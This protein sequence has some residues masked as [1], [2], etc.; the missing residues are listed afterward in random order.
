MNSIK[1]A[2]LKDI[3][4][5][6]HDTAPIFF[7][8]ET[9]P[10]E[11]TVMAQHLVPKYKAPANYN[12]PE[13]IEA[14]I[15]KK[16]QE[17]WDK[18]ALDPVSGEV[19]SFG[20]RYKGVNYIMDEF[21][22]LPEIEVA[23]LTGVERLAQVSNHRQ[24]IGHNIH[25]FDLPFLV[26]RFWANGMTMPLGWRSGNYWNSWFVDTMK[27]FGLGKWKDTI[28]LDRLARFLGHTTGKEG[29][30]GEK[31][32]ELLLADREAALKYLGKDL[33]LTQFVYE[34]MS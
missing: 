4:F 14:Y 22:D 3:G 16:E 26:R 24:W 34:K 11:K 2:E 23:I 19:V 29:Q 12:D 18:A 33:E 21:E 32:H 13:K 31:F 10:S 8:I 1:I 27:M 15:L 28:S 7:D 5:D 9:G 20:F 30:T 6:P 17:F 25:D